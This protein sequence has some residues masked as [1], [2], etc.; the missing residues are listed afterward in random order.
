MVIVLLS[1]VG[2]VLT[3]RAEWILNYFSPVSWTN[4]SIYKKGFGG[5]PMAYAFTM[6]LTGIL[7]LI[8]LIMHRQK[9]YSIEA[10]EE[11]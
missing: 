11:I 6:L 3:V 1:Q 4:L 5:V 10:M 8:L 7:V 9:E 2:K